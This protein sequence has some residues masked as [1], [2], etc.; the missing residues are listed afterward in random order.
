MAIDYRYTFSDFTDNLSA[1]E[2][3]DHLKKDRVFKLK[4]R[5][6]DSNFALTD[7]G[8]L[9]SVWADLVDLMTA[10]FTSDWLLSRDLRGSRNIL[11]ILPL[12]NPDIFQQ[13]HEHLHELL[14]WYTDDNW[15]FD[16]RQRQASMRISEEQPKL[17][18]PM[19][20]REVA[21][22]SGG[23]DAYAGLRYRAAHNSAPAYTLIGSGSNKPIRGKQKTMAKDTKGICLGNKQIDFIQVPFDFEYQKPKPSQ[24][25]LFRAHGFVFKLCGAICALLQEQSALH[26]YENGYGAFNLP[27]TK[28]DTTLAHTRSVHPISL[29][30][31]GEFVSNV[32]GQ[33]F[34]Y[35]NPFLFMT[36][37]EMCQAVTDHPSIAFNTSTCDSPQRKSERQC[38]YCSSCLLRRLSLNMTFKRDATPYVINN[39]SVASSTNHFRAMD[40]QAERIATIFDHDNTW[41]SWLELY[42]EFRQWI[43]YISHDRNQPVLDVQNNVLGLYHKHLQEWLQVRH[44]LKP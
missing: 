11:V 27:F 3:V 32:I 28:T 41:L 19:G 30:K 34:R 7:M 1:V 23:L 26:I 29:I 44:L 12:R 33:L 21:L 43:P 40:I 22:W 2:I 24:N 25:K 39:Y 8:A 16:F 42:P 37:A 15:T 17:L 18:L 20:C 35:E 5:V 36:K 31:T 14:R 38:G 10:V 6:N 4:V 9:N 13:H